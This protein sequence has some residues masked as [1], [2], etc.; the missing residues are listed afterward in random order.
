MDLGKRLRFKTFNMLKRVK[1]T[2]SQVGLSKKQRKENI[3]G[4]FELNPNLEKP[5][6]DAS[7]FLVDDVFTTGSTLTEAAR[8]LK[9]NGIKSVWALTLARD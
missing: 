8:I 1:K 9:R 2:S 4:A 5:A 3:K 7:V 6:G